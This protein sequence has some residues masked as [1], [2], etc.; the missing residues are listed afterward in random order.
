[1]VSSETIHVRNVFS[2]KIVYAF[3]SFF[4]FFVVVVFV[5]FLMKKIKNVTD[6]LFVDLTCMLIYLNSS[7]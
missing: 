1:M 4:L 5:C 2:A 7:S 3:F 6:L